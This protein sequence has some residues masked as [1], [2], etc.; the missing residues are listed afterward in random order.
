M[1]CLEIWEGPGSLSEKAAYIQSV[2]WILETEDT[3]HSLKMWHPVRHAFL[4]GA[5]NA[6]AVKALKVE[7]KRRADPAYILPEARLGDGQLFTPEQVWDTT[8]LERR[9]R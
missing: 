9:G 1:L 8:L 4:E 5:V 3:A 6:V 7:L 2:E